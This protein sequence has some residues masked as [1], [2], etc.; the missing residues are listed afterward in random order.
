ME[1]EPIS[2]WY[3]RGGYVPVFLASGICYFDFAVQAGSPTHL[4]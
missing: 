4:S 3:A 1:P 2:T